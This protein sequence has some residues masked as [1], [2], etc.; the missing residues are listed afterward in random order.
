MRIRFLRVAAVLLS[1]GLASSAQTQTADQ[2]KA[3][4]DSLSPDEQS[5]LLQG[6]LGKGDGTGKTDKKL[7]NPDTVNPKSDDTRDTHSIRKQET[8]D[9]RILRQTDEDPELRADDSVLIELTPNELAGNG[10]GDQSSPSGNNGNSSNGN[11]TNGNGGV[12][13][14]PGANN[15]A[16]TVG[17]NGASGIAGVLAGSANN[18]GNPN[19]NAAGTGGNSNNSN[20]VERKPKTD[21]EKEKSDKFRKRVLSNNPYV[22]NHL[23]V[24]EIPGMPAIP[25]AG[26][27]ALE[28]TKRLNADP[29]FMDYVV[30]LTLLRLRAVR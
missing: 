9:G 11:A 6:V 28:A 15:A 4:K 30:K 26:L 2:I 12:N 7:D 10:S 24:L 8:Y 20:L 22:L 23:G 1:I 16:G 18:G 3:L 29:G 13:G 14:M 5:S 25:L 19:S 21:E 17:A 27:T